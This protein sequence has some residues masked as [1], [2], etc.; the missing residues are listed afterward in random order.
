SAVLNSRHLHANPELS[1]QEFKTSSFVK[2]RLEQVSLF[3]ALSHLQFPCPPVP[4]IQLAHL[5]PKPGS[6]IE[7]RILVIPILRKG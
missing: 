4:A 6:A 1:F 3:N 2:A 7:Y 5:R